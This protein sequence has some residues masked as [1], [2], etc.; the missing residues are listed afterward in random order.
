MLFVNAV[1]VLHQTILLAPSGPV[2]FKTQHPQP[3]WLTGGTLGTPP[4]SVPTWFVLPPTASDGVPPDG[5][6]IFLHLGFAA[7]ERQGLVAAVVNSATPGSKKQTHNCASEVLL[8]K[9]HKITTWVC[10][11]RPP[12]AVGLLPG[13][14]FAQQ[15]LE[16]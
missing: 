6:E 15:T 16:L 7:T 1:P 9:S 3:V 11:F 8:A 4:P 12:V 5:V 13:S 14:I 2:D 10:P